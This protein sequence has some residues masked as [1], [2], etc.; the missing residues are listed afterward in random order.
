M[1]P[2]DQENNAQMGRVHVIL[3]QIT[4]DINADSMN[5]Y[6]PIAITNF[7]LIII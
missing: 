5:H 4:Y 3:A 7:K 1:P 2:M 6:R